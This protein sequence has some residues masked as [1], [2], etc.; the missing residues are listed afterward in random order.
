M[1]LYKTLIIKHIEL[2]FKI[3]LAIYRLIVPG[4]IIKKRLLKKILS[5]YAQ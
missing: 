4:R 3:K 1:P 2:I 5:N